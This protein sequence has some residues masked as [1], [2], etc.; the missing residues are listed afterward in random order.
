RELR[1]RLVDLLAGAPVPGAAVVVQLV[2]PQ[3]TGEAASVLLVVIVPDDA[4]ADDVE[5]L[6]G[7]LTSAV[8]RW[9]G[10]AVS[11]HAATATKTARDLA[12]G[13]PATAAWDE[14]TRTR[15]RSELTRLGVDAPHRPDGSPHAPGT[16]MLGG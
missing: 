3:R 8:R 15:V 6:A 16:G 5:A 13:A 2:P 12:G 9:T 7:D 14:A 11:V 4:L 10:N 1:R